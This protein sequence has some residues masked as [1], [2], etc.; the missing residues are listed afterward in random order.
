MTCLVSIT[1]DWRYKTRERQNQI[2]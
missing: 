2:L 1:H